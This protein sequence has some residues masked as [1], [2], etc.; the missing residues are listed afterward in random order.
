MLGLEMSN[1]SRPHRPE[2]L[3]SRVQ[4]MTDMTSQLLK[5]KSAGGGHRRE[6]EESGGNG[7]GALTTTAAA[8]GGRRPL[9]T[10]VMVLQ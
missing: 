7:R 5:A 1:S 9:L 8:P 3:K 6:E 2:E 10:Q 4:K